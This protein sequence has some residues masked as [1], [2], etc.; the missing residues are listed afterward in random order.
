MDI[1]TIDACPPTLP[2][3]E[4]SGRHCRYTLRCCDPH[5]SAA[6]TPALF[7]ESSSD[8]E[9]VLGRGS[10]Y[11]G[12]P[13]LVARQYLVATRHLAKSHCLVATRHL[14]ESQRLVAN[15]RLTASMTVPSPTS[16]IPNQS[17]T[18]GRSPRKMTANMATSTTLS[19]SIGA[20][21]DAS[22]ICSARK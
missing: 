6:V 18:L 12:E 13:V 1:S 10:G 21:L 11:D 16:E 8:S 14:V 17:F 15:Q 19:L 9:S 4:P 5:A 22:P 2:H 3:R 7:C 20:T